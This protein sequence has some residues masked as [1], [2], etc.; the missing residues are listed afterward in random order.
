MLSLWAASY[1]AGRQLKDKPRT[2]D[3]HS[4]LDRL[5]KAVFHRITFNFCWITQMSIQ[6]QIRPIKI[7]RSSKFL[8][9][10]ALANV[11]VFFFF[12]FLFFFPWLLTE[13]QHLFIRLKIFRKNNNQQF[14]EAISILII[15]NIAFYGFRIK[16]LLYL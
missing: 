10:V 16:Y 2:Q 7:T 4:K 12:L 13:Y 15:R 5:F 3:N 8:L 11:C 14:L 1:L 6:K 9:P